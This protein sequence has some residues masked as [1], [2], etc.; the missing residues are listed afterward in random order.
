MSAKQI[1]ADLKARLAPITAADILIIQPPPVRGIGTTGGFKLILE[2]QGGH[3][4]KQLEETARNLAKAAAASPAI[5]SSYVTFNTKTP[6]IYADIDRVKAQMPGVPDSAVFSTLQTYLG[7]TFVNDFNLFGHTFQVLAQAD[8]PF[9][10]NPDQ[11]NQLQTRSTSGAMV[12][13]GSVV[14]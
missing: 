14:N 6:R 1:L 11:I 10:A 7:S 9:R 4:S 13:L 8:A 2:D 12:P 3:G 5:S